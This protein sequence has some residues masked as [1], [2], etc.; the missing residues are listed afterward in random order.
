MPSRKP[1]GDVAGAQL[2]HQRENESADGG[3]GDAAEAAQDDDGE[4]LE[5]GGIAHGRIDDEDGPQECAGRRGETGAQGEG[6]RVD[7]VDLDAHQRGR[8]PVLEGGAHRLAELGA[9]DERV[10]S[11]DQRECDDEHEQPVPGDGYRPQHQRVRRERR[12][13]RLRHAR[14]GQLLEVLQRDPGAD[15]HQHG[16][17]DVGAP[18]PAQ[19]RELD[20]RAEHDPEQHRQR[21]GEE[22]VHAG[23]HHPHEHHVGAE[24]VELAV[25]EVHHPHDAEDQRQPDAQQRIG[26]AQDERIECV[27]EQLIHGGL[28]L[29]ALRR[30]SLDY[31]SAGRGSG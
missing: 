14:P 25:G 11:R 8:L 19:Q 30:R 18:Q 26:A 22:E 9:I 5:R 27:L 7:G 17:V 31:A 23:Q 10:G 3:A 24:A 4:G 20:R 13:D 29:P 1:G 15:H 12:V 21:Q 28:P 2:F 6:C 16:G